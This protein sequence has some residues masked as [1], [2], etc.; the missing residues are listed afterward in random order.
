MVFFSVKIDLFWFYGFFIALVEQHWWVVLLVG[1]FVLV[2]FFDL[3]FGS[4]V[5][6]D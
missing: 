2:C 1:G 4:V 3:G 5:V 6:C